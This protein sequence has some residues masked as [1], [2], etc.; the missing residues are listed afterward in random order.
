MWQRLGKFVINNRL[1]LLI[2]LVL[3]TI[4]MGYYASKVKLS[5]EF[6]KAVPTDNPKY[7]EYLSFKNTFGDDGNLLVVGIQS[8]K[9][10]ELKNFTAYREMEQQIKKVDAGESVGYGCETILEKDAVIA[11]VR[12]ILCSG[13]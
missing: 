12:I 2:L 8:D 1:V 7:Q 10:F 5:Y 4:V 11:T 6:S 3:A 9:L 13:I